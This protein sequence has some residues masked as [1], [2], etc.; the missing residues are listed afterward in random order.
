[1]NSVEFGKIECIY[2]RVFNLYFQFNHLSG[3]NVGLKIG[4]TRVKTVLFS[5]VTSWLLTSGGGNVKRQTNPATNNHKL[6]AMI[7][8]RRQTTDQLRVLPF[9]SSVESNN[10]EEN[11]I[12]ITWRFVNLLRP[13]LTKKETSKF[14][15]QS[16]FVKTINR[17]ISPKGP[18]LRKSWPCYDVIM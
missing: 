9:T 12:T 7:A 10:A 1:M 5:L 2:G 4:L 3:K 15:H 14:T 16:M 6:A 13:K 8:P 18:V 17:W 11:K